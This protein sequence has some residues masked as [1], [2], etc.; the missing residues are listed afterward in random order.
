MTACRKSSAFAV[1]AIASALVT[2]G[3]VAGQSKT[4]RLEGVWRVVQVTTS[5]PNAQVFKP[6]TTL[7]IFS[8]RHYSRTEVH[9]DQPRPTVSDVATASA[10]ELR[11]VWGPFVGEAGIFELTDNLLTLRP[12]VAKNPAAMATGAF[13]VYGYSLTGKSL[14]L[15][16]QRNQSGPVPGPVTVKLDRVE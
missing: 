5:G 7:A 12:L 14:T 10:D 8:G 3:I 16:M 13:T 9:A 1:V 6:L 2:S 4:T 11:A 15:T